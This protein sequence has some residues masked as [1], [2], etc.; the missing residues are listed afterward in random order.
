MQYI[1]LSPVAAFLLLIN[2]PAGILANWCWYASILPCKDSQVALI[3]FASVH[4]VCN[5]LKFQSDNSVYCMIPDPFPSTS[6]GK[7]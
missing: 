6:F 7:G 5:N 4:V 2:T 3:D 1:E